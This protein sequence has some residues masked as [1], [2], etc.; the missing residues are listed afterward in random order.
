MTRQDPGAATGAGLYPVDPP[1]AC[2]HEAVLHAIGR[3]GGQSVR[4]ACSTSGCECLRYA[5]AEV[6]THG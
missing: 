1:C 6:V 2:S 4:T 3:R 5:A